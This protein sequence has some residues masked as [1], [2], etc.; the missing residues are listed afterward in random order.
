ML[1]LRLLAKPTYR[2]SMIG[3]KFELAPNRPR[4]TVVRVTGEQPMLKTA[5]HSSVVT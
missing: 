3:A 1:D 4:G 2:A 5:L